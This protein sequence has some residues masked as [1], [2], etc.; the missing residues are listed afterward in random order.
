MY[1]IVF[2]SVSDIGRLNCSDLAQSHQSLEAK[3]GQQQLV[4]ERDTAKED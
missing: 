4:F 2:L 1:R 3:Q